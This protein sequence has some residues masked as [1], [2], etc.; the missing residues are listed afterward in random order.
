MYIKVKMKHR[1]TQQVWH[2]AETGRPGG[3]AWMAIIGTQ[4][5]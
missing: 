3:A 5:P 1:R 4:A 2:S